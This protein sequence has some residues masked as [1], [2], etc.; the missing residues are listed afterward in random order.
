MPGIIHG[1]SAIAADWQDVGRILPEGPDVLALS[2]FPIVAFRSA[3]GDYR[4]AVSSQYLIDEGHAHGDW[5]IC[6]RRS[7]WLGASPRFLT[8]CWTNQIGEQFTMAGFLAGLPADIRIIRNGQPRPVVS[9]DSD[10]LEKPSHCPGAAEAA[11]GVEAAAMRAGERSIGRRSADRA[12]DVGRIVL[13]RQ[14]LVQRAAECREP[15]HHRPPRFTSSA[16]AFSR[17]LC[18]DAL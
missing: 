18:G 9:A 7:A 6:R 15:N 13:L 3:K 12:E 1:N 4:E 10:G 16:C 11:P 2:D 17:A 14:P 8:T 5:Q